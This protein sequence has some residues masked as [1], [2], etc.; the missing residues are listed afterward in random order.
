M[1]GLR[2]NY[3]AWLRYGN[4]PETF[5]IG[6]GTYNGQTIPL[7]DWLLSGATAAKVPTPYLRKHLRGD[8]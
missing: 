6:Y 5:G 4:A 8:H 2:I 3:E 7:A 1:Y